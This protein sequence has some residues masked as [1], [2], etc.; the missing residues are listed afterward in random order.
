MSLDVVQKLERENISL[1]SF[2]KRI[3]A[4]CIDEVLISI[5]FLIIY[6]NAF[7]TAKSYEEIMMLVSNF[8]WQIIT[9]KI[10]YQTFF[11]WYYGASIGKIA[12]KITC[13]DVEILDKPNF[14]ASLS[15]AF[16]RAFGET[17][18]YLGF[19]WAFGNIARQTW[20]D[21]TAKTVVIDV[22]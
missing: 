5:L 3:Y 14:I 1:A 9:L 21:K 4:Y 7:E 17:C 10:I 6:W 12:V 15:R 19:A 22:A 13:I 2:S 16:M 8:V 18:L 20:H 11:T